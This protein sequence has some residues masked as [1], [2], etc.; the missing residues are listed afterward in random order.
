MAASLVLRLAVFYGAIFLIVGIQL[1]FWPLWFK[2][3]GMDAA[4]I[5]I[6]LSLATWVR[7]VT[8][9]LIAQI[10]DRSGER[11]RPIIVLCWAT[12]AVFALF[13]V[14]HGF[15][16]LVAVALLQG[17]AFSAT[18]PLI[19]TLA[20]QVSHAHKLDYG[21]IRLWG[22][23][24]FILAAIL[25]GRVLHGRP[26]SVVLWL[27]LAGCLITALA[28]HWL[29]DHRSP[30]AQRHHGAPILRLL[31]DRTLAVF[32]AATSLMQASHAA[33][34]GFSSLHWRTAGISDEMIGLLWAE[35]VV[36]EVALFAFSGAVVRAVGPIRLILLGAAGGAVR[37]TA[38]GLSTDL[39]VL[40][41]VQLLHACTFAMMHL[42]AMHLLLRAA[43]AQFS[44][45]AQSLYSGLSS[46]VA[47]GIAMAASGWLYARYAGGAFLVMAALSAAGGLIALALARLWRDHAASGPA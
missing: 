43:P 21:R 45:T 2:W 31:N 6:I 18:F 8:N 24:T 11:R 37:W 40:L 29:P 22:S 7:A 13:E 42:G 35:G 41:A 39:T 27:I 3:R 46:G 19:E 9:P 34:Y 10:A 15:W 17:I 25:G 4:E 44:A 33:Y 32:F 26:E 5:G 16:A 30:P 23:V 20:M 1:P 28:A 38:T 14:T 36:A 47:M 12:L